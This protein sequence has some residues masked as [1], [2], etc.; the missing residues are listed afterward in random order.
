[1]DPAVLKGMQKAIK[2]AQT[3]IMAWLKEGIA[4]GD[5]KLEN[6]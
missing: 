3:Q 6:G 4:A 5:F 1:V 2:P